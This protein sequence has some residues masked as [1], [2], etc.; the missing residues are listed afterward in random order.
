VPFAPSKR[1]VHIAI[2]ASGRK[3]VGGQ[4]PPFGGAILENPGDLIDMLL[5]TSMAAFVKRV[6]AATLLETLHHLLGVNPAKHVMLPGM[7]DQAL[8]PTV[9]ETPKEPVDIRL[10]RVGEN[11]AITGLHMDDVQHVLAL[12][13]GRMDQPLFGKLI[14]P[15]VFNNGRRRF[16]QRGN[17]FTLVHAA[18][19]IAG[20]FGAVEDQR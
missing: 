15:I 4:S 17:F 5:R 13:G 7:T 11:H 3:L 2:E 14:A 10:F 16:S 18:E 1:V 20:C 12:Y 19:E 9:D 8:Y 6:I